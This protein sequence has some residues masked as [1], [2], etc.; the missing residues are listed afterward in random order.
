MKIN[1][2]DILKPALTL[3]VICLIVTALLAGTNILTKD[4]IAEQ[5]VL[6]A[7]ES[8]KLVLSD[9]EDFEESDGCY[10]GLSAGEA[11][12]YVFETEAK[13]YGGSVKVMT[14]IDIDGNITGV[15][16]LEHEE[17][18]GL[19]ANAEKTSFTDQYVQM[20]PTDGI[21]L[22]KNKAP[23]EGEI[24]ALTGASIT[25][26]AVTDAVNAA[27]EQYMSLKGGA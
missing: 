6:L 8:R 25:S 3:F 27:I 13:G 2:K 17:T 21:K 26:K 23:A 22:V 9:A 19:G 5:S 18:P 1:A 11:V 10:I 24:E 7:S 14:G 20:A 15:T 16:V 4:K 12:G